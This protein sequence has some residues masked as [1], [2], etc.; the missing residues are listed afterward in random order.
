MESVVEISKAVKADRGVYMGWALGGYLA[1]DLA[2]YR[3]NDF[4]AVIGINA[5]AGRG[6]ANSA[7]AQAS[8]DSYLHPRVHNSRRSAVMVHGNTSPAAP[9][10]FRREV[11][12]I[13]GQIAPGVLSGDF[14]Y[15][16]IDHDLTGGQARGIDTSKVDVHL[17]SGELEVSPGPTGAAALAAQIKGSTF[18]VIKGGSYLPMCDD[19][20]RFRQHLMP[21]LNKILAKNG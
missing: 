8:N 1:L 4:R 7:A 14:Y 3:P 16:S 17:L 19:Y 12:W 11:S 15:Y 2:L 18:A 21:V 5:G 6:P 20:P 13:Y 9:E 10:P